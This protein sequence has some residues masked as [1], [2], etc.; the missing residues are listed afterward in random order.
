MSSQIDTE[1]DSASP[2]PCS[3]CTVFIAPIAKDPVD[4]SAGAELSRT[5]FMKTHLT[6]LINGKGNN[7][8]NTLF[9]N[10]QKGLAFTSFKELTGVT[11]VDKVCYVQ[12]IDQKFLKFAQDNC[13]D[14]SKLVKKSTYEEAVGTAEC[15]IVFGDDVLLNIFTEQQYN[16]FTPEQLGT[17]SLMTTYHMQIRSTATYG[18]GT[19]NQQLENALSN[20]W[21]SLRGVTQFIQKLYTQIYGQEPDEDYLLLSSPQQLVHQLDAV[22]G[23]F[24]RVINKQVIRAVM[25]QEHYDMSAFDYQMLQQ[26]V[27]V[28]NHLYGINIEVQLQTVPYDS[29]S[30]KS[31]KD[32]ILQYLHDCPSDSLGCTDGF[33]LALGLVEYTISST[34]DYVSG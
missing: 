12:S 1:I 15:S 28:L 34:D 30:G 23:T 17:E 8:L 11:G 26:E 21:L 5:P 14:E 13:A 18:Q 31:Q 25:L 24:L 9:D 22:N 16:V 4:K 27:E 19:G 3:D 33:D 32:F 2:G 29:E 7:E 6:A 20:A 10:V